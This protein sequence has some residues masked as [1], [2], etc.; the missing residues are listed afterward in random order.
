MLS[1][2]DH[3]NIVKLKDFQTDLD[4]PCKDGTTLRALIIVME[5][6]GGGELFSFLSHTGPFAES[7]T[8]TYSAQ[9]LRGM[10]HC[11]ANGV[12]HRDIKPENIFLASDFTLKIGDCESFGF[13]WKLVFP[14][15]PA[16]SH[17]A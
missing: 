11:H 3:G 4:Y 6:V 7:L 17:A 13:C 16:F 12:S 9:L 8:R 2:L 14:L 15:S 5:L 10:A 1:N